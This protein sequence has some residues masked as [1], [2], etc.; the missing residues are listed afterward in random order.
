[1]ADLKVARGSS[2]WGEAR[3]E[4]PAARAVVAEVALA[5]LD[6]AGV[7]EL[8]EV[9]VGDVLVGG[10]GEGVGGGEAARS[11]RKWQVAVDV[12]ESGSGIN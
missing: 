7:P 2:P 11:A 10:A 5:G 12:V 6:L 1:M 4:Q 3:W 8:V 9:A